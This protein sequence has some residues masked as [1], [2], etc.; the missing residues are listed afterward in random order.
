MSVPLTNRERQI[1]DL[2]AAGL[3]NKEI[4][5]QLGI[6]IQTVRNRISVIMRKMAA[7]NR[8][9]LAV[10]IILAEN[11]QLPSDEARDETRDR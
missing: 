1:A 7:R 3:G 11:G 9:D 10:K 8:T 2:V 4:A 6:R 5:H